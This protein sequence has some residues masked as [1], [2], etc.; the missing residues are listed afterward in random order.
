M[1]I[2]KNI[3]AARLGEFFIRK[4]VTTVPLIKHIK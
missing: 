1:K 3:F 2:D 4:A